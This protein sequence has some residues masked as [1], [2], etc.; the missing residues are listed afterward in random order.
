MEC[1]KKSTRGKNR[2]EP[3]RLLAFSQTPNTNSLQYDLRSSHDLYSYQLASPQYGTSRPSLSARTGRSIRK[4]TRVKSKLT[5]TKQRIKVIKSLS[6]N[7]QFYSILISIPNILTHSSYCQ[8]YWSNG[9]KKN[10]PK[11]RSGHQ[12]AE[13]QE[14]LEHHLSS[15]TSS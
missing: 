10:S 5:E 7:G 6:H 3:Y 8:P 2:A 1:K 9:K 4:L 15:H 11:G 13:E 14:L 12:K